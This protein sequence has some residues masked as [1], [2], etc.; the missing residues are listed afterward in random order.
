M[1]RQVGGAPENRKQNNYKAARCAFEQPT[2]CLHWSAERGKLC[3]ASK[4][5]LS[6]FQASMAKK[7]EKKETVPADL[8]FSSLTF[9]L[10]DVLTF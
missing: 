2:K 7:A 9:W 10:F 1:G 3:S 6:I 5:L 8:R 4:A